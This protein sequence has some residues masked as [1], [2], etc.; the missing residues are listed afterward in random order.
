MKH[1]FD[2]RVY[3]PSIYSKEQGAGG[4]SS[5]SVQA[6]PGGP[7]DAGAVAVAPRGTPDRR[8]APR[9]KNGIPLFTCTLPQCPDE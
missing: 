3:N 4:T 9:V 7:L 1:Y 8:S 2:E 6:P 5:S